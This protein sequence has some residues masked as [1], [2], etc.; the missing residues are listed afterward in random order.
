[1]KCPNC[2]RSISNSGRPF[3]EKTLRQHMKDGCTK[4]YECPRCGLRRSRR[5]RRFTEERLQQHMASGDCKERLKARKEREAKKAPYRKLQLGLDPA[6]DDPM[7]VHPALGLA[8]DIGGDL[9]D[10]AYWAL[11]WELG[12]R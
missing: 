9:P 8:D 4:G 12:Y 10:G 7:D 5:G 6:V 3:D 1:M 11:A 2:G